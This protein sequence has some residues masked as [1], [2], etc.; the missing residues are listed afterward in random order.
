MNVLVYF[1]LGLICTL[2]S[3]WRWTVDPTLR[4]SFIFV[5]SLL[6]DISHANTLLLV[7][8]FSFFLWVFFSPTSWWLFRLQITLFLVWKS[9]SIIGWNM[10]VFVLAVSNFCVKKV[11]QVFGLCLREAYTPFVAIFGLFLH[12]R[13]TFPHSHGS[14]NN[15]CIKENSGCPDLH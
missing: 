3:F 6:V 11:S 9:L 2:P 13:G 5:L 10:S 8:L 4:E 1:Y 15:K 7:N 12:S 14:W